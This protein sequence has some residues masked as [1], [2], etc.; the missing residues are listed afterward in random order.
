VIEA[1]DR[2]HR[3]NGSPAPACLPGPGGSAA[4]GRAAVAYRREIL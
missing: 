3:R 1:D 2:C 4:G